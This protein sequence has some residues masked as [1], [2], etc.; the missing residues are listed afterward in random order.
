MVSRG[1][2]ALYTGEKFD[3]AT[4]STDDHGN[5]IERWST[6]TFT[7]EGKDWCNW[8]DEIDHINCIQESLGCLDD[9]TR[10]IRAE[11]GGLVLCHSSLPVSI[12]EL[13]VAI[14]DGQLP[15]HPLHK[16]CWPGAP[17][18]K[19]RGSQPRQ[20]E[21]MRTI[22]SIVR[23]Y[24]DGKPEEDF[25]AQFPHAAGFTNRTY[26]W[27]G[28]ASELTQVQ[29]LMME[30]MLVPFEFFSRKSLVDCEGSS[31]DEVDED[32]HGRACRNCHGDDGRGAQ[33][34]AE[35]SRVARLPEIPRPG[36]QHGQTYKRGIESIS[37][38][39]K[40]DLFELCTHLTATIYW[41]LCD[42][43]HNT[44]RVIEGQIHGIAT[45][46]VTVPSRTRGSER[47]RLG[48]LLFGY[49]LGLDKWLMGAPMQFLLLDLGHHDLGFD[50][51]NEILR[52][53]AYL[54]GEKTSLREWLAACL[55]YNLYR[56]PHGGLDP[57]V[58]RWSGGHAELLAAA[59]EAGVSAREWMDSQLKESR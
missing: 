49:A 4:D 54:G 8:D 23:G 34:D 36:P 19:R 22:E 32:L 50:P 30:R 6:W 12:D 39:S 35:I 48:R 24:L 56:N 44:F 7:D 57:L 33:L 43:H 5:V 41:D 53:Y 11:I 3:R 9:K 13:L 59:R 42:C 14:A 26:E 15:E 17:G 38:P 58:Q 45:G 28:P 21:T 1:W 2:E 29:R 46:T 55:W 20:V 51:K 31:G 16:G 40:R 27:L 18:T 10:S 47:T 52:V 25:V 37:E